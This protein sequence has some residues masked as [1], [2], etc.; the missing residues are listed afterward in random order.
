MCFITYDKMQHLDYI[1]E[2]SSAMTTLDDFLSE[3][4]QD[5]DFKKEYDALAPEFTDM[6]ALV[7]MQKNNGITQK[8]LLA[9]PKDLSQRKTQD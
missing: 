8:E 6:Q 4:L 9:S 7:D 2:K 5:P 1:R 3:Q